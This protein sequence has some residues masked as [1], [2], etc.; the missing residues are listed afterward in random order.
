MKDNCI[1]LKHTLRKKTPIFWL[2]ASLRNWLRQCYF[3]SMHE[4]TNQ[5]SVGRK[6]CTVLVSMCV[7]KKVTQVGQLFSL[8]TALKKLIKSRK[9]EEFCVSPS[10]WFCAENE[11]PASGNSLVVRGVLPGII[12]LF[13]TKYVIPRQIKRKI[14]DLAE[15]IGTLAAR[16]KKK[17]VIMSFRKDSSVFTAAR[18]VGAVRAWLHAFDQQNS[19]W[20]SSEPYRNS[21]LPS[22]GIEIV[23]KSI[24]IIRTLLRTMTTR[25]AVSQSPRSLQ[26]PGME[27]MVGRETSCGLEDKPLNVSEAQGFLLPP[28]MREAFPDADLEWADYQVKYNMLLSFL[29][30]SDFIAYCLF[31]SL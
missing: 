7:S 6:N 19:D 9:C 13:W 28:N 12:I 23:L 8:L 5:H 4:L 18:T 21:C 25:L 2:V 24:S 30:L 10:F 17:T 14:S 31:F 26:I 11:P 3:L 27:V 15:A 22:Q 16:G 29:S 20:T 1:P